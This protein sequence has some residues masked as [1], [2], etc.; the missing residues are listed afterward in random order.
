MQKEFFIKKREQLFERL[1]DDSVAILFSSNA[2]LKTA[3]EHYAFTPNRNFYYLTGLDRENFILVMKKKQGTASSSIYIEKHDPVLAKWVGDRMLAD[4]VQSISGISDIRYV[5]DI[6]KDIGSLLGGYDFQNVYFDFEYRGWDRTC[7]EQRAFAN[8]LKSRFPS[9]SLRNLY[10]IISSMRLIKEPEEI[11]KIRQ[12][13]SI[14]QKG[15]L[16]IL[17]NI[18]PGIMEYELEAYFDF[19]LKSCGVK[20]FAFKTIAA[21]GKN[22]TILH[23]SQNNSMMNEND[24][25]LFDLGA[26]FEYYNADISRTFPINGKYSQ[27]QK[28]VYDAVLQAQQAVTQAAKP[29]VPF[30]VLNDTAK[31][32]LAEGCRK[33]GLIKEDSELSEYYY[34]GVSHYLGLDT[35][36]VGTRDTV[37]KE[38]MV[39]T[40]EPG[41]YIASEGI[42][43]RIED[44]LLISHDGAEVLSK[45]IIKD[46]FDVEAYIKNR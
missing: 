33:L 8:E 34:H 4:E 3:D 18:R 7:N 17:A 42:G 6:N 13:I 46:T 15:I 45:D 43:I 10:H 1:A 41:L 29:G 35:H 16:N 30:S 21:S 11:E 14:T 39:I 2:P 24:L 9:V 28:D 32:V 31:K 19:T 37:L 36:D 20:D 23:Y 12:A 40:N 22:A 27:R 26:Q 25:I 5:D 38:G 44:D